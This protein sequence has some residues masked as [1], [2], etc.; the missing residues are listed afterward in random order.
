MIHT[1][2]A[3]KLIFVFGVSTL[4]EGRFPRRKS[5]LKNC[6]SQDTFLETQIEESSKKIIEKKGF[7]VQ[8]YEKN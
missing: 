5:V 1:I 6:W 7:W 4:F 3:R 2:R 8:K